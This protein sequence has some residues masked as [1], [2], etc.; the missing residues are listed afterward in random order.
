MANIEQEGQLKIRMC[1]PNSVC[2]PCTPNFCE[3]NNVEMEEDTQL[4][5]DEAED[6]CDPDPHILL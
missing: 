2:L 1:S 3:L 5:I 6:E 4:N